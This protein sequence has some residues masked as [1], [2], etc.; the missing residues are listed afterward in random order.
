MEPL[1]KMNP[2]IKAKWIEALRSGRYGQCKESLHLEGDGFCCLGVLYD[3]M[4]P[5]GWDKAE[6]QPSGTGY[7]C[8]FHKF[9]VA[10]LPPDV[11]KWAGIDYL[12]GDTVLIY[13]EN[14][15]TLAGL[16]DNGK[17]FSEI[18]DV[19]EREL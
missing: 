16:N 2:E 6:N 9:S 8:A 10:V 18:A 17:T 13:P 3:L 19:I 1:P 5:K 14:S 7:Q 15:Y 12:R 4:D 11:I